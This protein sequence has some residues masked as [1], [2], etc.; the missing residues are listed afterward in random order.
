MDLLPITPDV[1]PPEE[2]SAFKNTATTNV[3]KKH[4]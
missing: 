3:E 1:A 4:H 2:V